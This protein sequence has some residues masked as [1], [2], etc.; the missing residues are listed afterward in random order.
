MQV[1]QGVKKTDLATKEKLDGQRTTA[2][3]SSPFFNG[4]CN[5]VKI[6]NSHT[7]TYI[8]TNTRILPV[9]ANEKCERALEILLSF[10]IYALLLLHI[11]KVRCYQKQAMRPLRGHFHSDSAGTTTATLCAMCHDNERILPMMLMLMMVV[12]VNGK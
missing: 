10:Y 12:L 1:S 9:L 5:C 8:Q 3:Q 7:R 6:Y 11:V 2:Q 4:A